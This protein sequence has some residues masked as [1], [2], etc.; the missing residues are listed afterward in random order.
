S[1]PIVVQCPNTACNQP[2][3]VPDQYAGMQGKCPKCGTLVQFP[4]A[5]GASAPAPP[6]PTPVPPPPPQPPAPPAPGT[7]AMV[8][9]PAAPAYE[10]PA[11][12]AP[13][14]PTGYTPSGAGGGYAPP[15]HGQW[16]AGPAK[17]PMPTDQL[18]A[19]ITLPTGLFFLFLL[20]LATFLPW[21]SMGPVS[22]SGV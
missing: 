3:Q 20:F 17:P 12:Q 6:P 9:P 8:P 2:L 4:A 22:I 21:T 10:P 19:L 15:D 13:P 16:P 5:G 18:I 11:Y 14:S 7:Y 1:M